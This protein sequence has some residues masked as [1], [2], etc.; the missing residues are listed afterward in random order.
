M[1]IAAVG[2]MNSRTLDID[3]NL[4]KIRS[5][6]KEASNLSAELILLP[7]LCLTGYRADEKFSELAQPL[8]GSFTQELSRI[9][10]SNNGIYIY[11]AIP[12]KD[13]NGG[14]PYNTAVLVGPS[15]V[16]ASYQKIHLWSNETKYFSQGRHLEMADTPMGPAGMLI[17]FDMCFPEAARNYA[18]NGAEIL[19]YSSA[20]GN[21]TRRYVF[22]TMTQARSMENT[23]YALNANMV[24]TEKDTEFCGGSCIFDPYGNRI[25][26]CDEKEGIAC[27]EIDQNFLTA[28]RD[29]YPY[30]KKR[31]IEN[32]SS[33]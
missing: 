19:L 29:K 31:R 27:A 26:C 17:C 3:Y 24:G 9:S 5:M 32:W 25:A 22:D 11:T 8:G 6:V 1:S 20:C 18:L 33:I 14:K 10:R 13:S 12:E 30:L 28:A 15:G 23:C 2:Q 7:E 4:A 21:L 16:L